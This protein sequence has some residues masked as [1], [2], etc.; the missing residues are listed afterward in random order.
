MEV[1]SPSRPH[2]NLEDSL[3]HMVSQVSN[4]SEENPFK[5]DESEQLA[6]VLLI[7][8]EPI[9]I[10]VLNGM[11]NVLGMTCDSASSGPEGVAIVSRRLELVRRNK[12]RMYSLICLDYSMPEMDGPQVA[13]AIRSMMKSY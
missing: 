9:N 4:K 8:D 6:Q 7:D 11:F 2:T 1:E 13:R 5:Q 3:I 12:A 10:E